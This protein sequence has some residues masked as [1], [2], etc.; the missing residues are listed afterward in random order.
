MR[1]IVL[2]TIYI[3]IYSPVGVIVICNVRIY[4]NIISSLQN[5]R[6]GWCN[7]EILIGPLFAEQI[8]RQYYYYLAST[9]VRMYVYDAYAFCTF[10]DYTIN[11]ERCVYV[12]E[13]TVSYWVKNII[14][15]IRE[16]IVILYVRLK[17]ARIDGN[18]KII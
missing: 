4:Y 9:C 15:R 8:A 11:I 6:K 2:E 10:W 18:I 7:Y 17:T 1:Y 5:L 3:H 13:R 14:F 16:R 12:T